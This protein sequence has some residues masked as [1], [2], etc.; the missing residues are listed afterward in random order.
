MNSPS[1]SF[2]AGD[3]GRWEVTSVA[4]VIGETLE[5]VPFLEIRNEYLMNVPVDFSWL[6]RGITSTRRYTNNVQQ[7]NTMAA[8]PQL[9]R[10]EATCAALIPVRKSREWWDMTFE[11]RKQIFES[12]S[13]RYPKIRTVRNICPA[14]HASSTIAVIWASRLIS[15]HGSNTRP[16][17]PL[18]SRILSQLSGLQ[19]EWKYVDRE[20]DVRLVRSGG[21]RRTFHHSV[22]VS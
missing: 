10:P 17:T 20:V 15:W 22:R 18:L 5:W 16:R 9:G 4:P 3:R 1:F 19:K 21:P 14:S 7:V 13:I 6:L 8:Q 2:V 11:E 12:N